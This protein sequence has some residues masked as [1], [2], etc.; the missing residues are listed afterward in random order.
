MTWMPGR[1]KDE[2]YQTLCNKGWCFHAAKD[3][4]M[5]RMLIP[6][7]TKEQRNEVF[8]TLPITTDAW[9]IMRKHVYTCMTE[10]N[11]EYQARRHTSRGS[12]IVIIFQDRDDDEDDMVAACAW[13]RLIH[14]V[15]DTIYIVPHQRS[16]NEN[17]YSLVNRGMGEFQ[18]RVVSLDTYE[19]F[20]PAWA[21]PDAP[22]PNPPA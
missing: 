19:P 10:N 15:R 2:A 20:P 12:A 17:I 16:T 3:I 8:L 4:P 7:V 22:A 18:N 13:L 14:E 5:S 21:K 1:Y 11:V 6:D 9:E